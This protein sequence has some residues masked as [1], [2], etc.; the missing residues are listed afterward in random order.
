M[1]ILLDWKSQKDDYA[2]NYHELQ[3]TL[4]TKK[5]REQCAAIT[6]DAPSDWN[7]NS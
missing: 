5:L 2:K 6:A 1:T 4:E 7:E 3:K